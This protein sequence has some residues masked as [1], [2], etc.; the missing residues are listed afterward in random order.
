M[1]LLSRFLFFTLIFQ[2][3]ALSSLPPAV[4][5]AVT[6]RNKFRITKQAVL[7]NDTGVLGQFA[8]FN[9]EELNEITED[10]TEDFQ[11]FPD[12]T[13]GESSTFSPFAFGTSA[14]NL[15]AGVLVPIVTRALFILF[16]CWKVDLFLD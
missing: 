8:G 13:E 12:D 10:E 2:M 6:E 11:P 15:S 1:R 3:L 5:S 16:H 7:T 14:T 9:K 4:G